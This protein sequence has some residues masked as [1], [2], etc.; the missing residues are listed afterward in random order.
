VFC[1][2]AREPATEAFARHGERLHVEYDDDDL[3]LF[4][5]FTSDRRPHICEVGFTRQFG[6]HTDDLEYAGMNR[7]GLDAQI[8]LGKD[9]PRLPDAQIWGYPTAIDKWIAEVEATPGF[10]A[11]GERELAELTVVQE[12]V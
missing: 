6:F 4:E 1:S 12:D 8:E 10:R 7:L 11:F 9:E 2:E 3:L 5:V